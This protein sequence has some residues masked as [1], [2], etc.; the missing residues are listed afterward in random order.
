MV[1]GVE[2]LH[3]IPKLFLL[4][5]ILLYIEHS[6]GWSCIEE[7]WVMKHIVLYIIVTTSYLHYSFQH[8]RDP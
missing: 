5:S 8:Q 2:A 6:T 3:G 7:I 4:S 1:W